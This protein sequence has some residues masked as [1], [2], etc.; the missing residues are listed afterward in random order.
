MISNS[1]SLCRE[2]DAQSLG[3]RST[4]RHFRY[5]AAPRTNRIL[6]TLNSHSHSATSST[7]EPPTAV[8]GPPWQC[9][10]VDASPGEHT[11]VSSPDEHALPL[12]RLPPRR[13]ATRNF[14]Q[15]KCTV[16]G[17]DIVMQ[18]SVLPTFRASRYC[19]VSFQFAAG[20][21]RIWP[22]TYRTCESMK[23]SERC[24]MK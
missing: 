16:E 4:S 8:P 19:E 14:M 23:H 15:P 20:Q 17:A 21:T 3:R 1:N 24:G 10:C 13:S 5:R 12:G 7:T 22:D 6:P 9:F 11:D 2:R 18:S